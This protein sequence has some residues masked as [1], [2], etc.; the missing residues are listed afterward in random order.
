[1]KSSVNEKREGMARFYH[2]R[3]Q[4]CRPSGLEHMEEPEKPWEPL[5][6]IRHG[7]RS[8]ACRS[9]WHRQTASSKLAAR[10]IARLLQE[11]RHE[12]LCFADGVISKAFKGRPDG[13]HADARFLREGSD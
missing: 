4:G 1:M 8:R 2:G 6:P 9:R 5:A 12:A 10:A 13:V 11:S 7:L 3:L